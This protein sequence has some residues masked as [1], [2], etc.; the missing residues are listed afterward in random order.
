MKKSKTTSKLTGIWRQGN[1]LGRTLYI[2]N[3]CIGMV[4]TPAIA[5][6]IVAAMNAK[7]KLPCCDRLRHK[8]SCCELALDYEQNG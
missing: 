1:K 5:K 6:S 3:V 4:D 2:D 8:N 7:V